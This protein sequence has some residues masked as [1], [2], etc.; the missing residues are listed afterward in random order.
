MP[1]MPD[2]CIK[3]LDAAFGVEV[4]EASASIALGTKDDCSWHMAVEPHHWEK[5]FIKRGLYFCALC[6][7]EIG[8]WGAIGDG[9][10]PSLLVN[11]VG[12]YFSRGPT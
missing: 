6:N 5:D 12:S 2:E 10:P 11:H 1:D 3:M 4:H 8:D 7:R 9:W